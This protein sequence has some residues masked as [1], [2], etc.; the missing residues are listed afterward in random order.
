MSPK[1]VYHVIIAARLDAHCVATFDAAGRASAEPYVTSPRS[2]TV[3][4]L[5][6]C[7]VS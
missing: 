5:L 6:H 7:L 2:R 1:S 4:Q 3:N